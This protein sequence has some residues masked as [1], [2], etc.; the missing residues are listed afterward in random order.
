MFYLCFSISLPLIR[1]QHVMTEICNKGIMTYSFWNRWLKH[2]YSTTFTAFPRIKK[3]VVKKYVVKKP[4]SVLLLKYMIK[5]Y[6]TSVVKNYII[7]N[8]ALLFKSAVRNYILLVSA[9]GQSQSKHAWSNYCPPMTKEGL[10]VCLFCFFPNFEDIPNLFFSVS[11][12]LSLLHR[13]RTNLSLFQHVQGNELFS[14]CFSLFSTLQVIIG[15]DDYFTNLYISNWNKTQE[16]VLTLLK[17]NYL[18]FLMS[19]LN[20]FLNYMYLYDSHYNFQ[21]SVSDFSQ[22]S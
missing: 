20:K 2:L 19:Y 3:S 14:S 5:K 15:D 17:S 1:A 13:F 16:I 22:V 7:E 11:V 21:L 8:P 18:F 4:R 6:T 9:G 12:S 10:F